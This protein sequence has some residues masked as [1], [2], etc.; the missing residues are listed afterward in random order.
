MKFLAMVLLLILLSFL[1]GC[2]IS[3]AFINYKGNDRYFFRTY[4]LYKLGEV[5]FGT[6]ILAAIFNTF[7]GAAVIIPLTLKLFFPTS[8]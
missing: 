8:I 6:V 2:V 5:N 3:S 1:L 4:D 7:L